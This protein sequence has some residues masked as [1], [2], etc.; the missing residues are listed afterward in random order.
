MYSTVALMKNSSIKSFLI[1]RCFVKDLDVVVGL[2]TIWTWSVKMS[3]S[4]FF[5]FFK[6]F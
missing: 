2:F 6:R 1:E 3:K 4:L 5:E